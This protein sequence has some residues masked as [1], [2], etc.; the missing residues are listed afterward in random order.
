MSVEPAGDATPQE[1]AS[2]RE[3]EADEPLSRVQRWLCGGVGL[4][5]GGAGGVATFL[6]GSNVGGAPLLIGVGA[7][8]AY[9][10]L[11]GQR[12]TRL[13]AG[14]AS[15]QLAR[16]RRA[17]EDIASNPEVPEE[18][19]AEIAEAV[20]DADLRLSAPAVTSLRSAAN[21]QRRASYYELS[22]QTAIAR[23]RPDLYASQPRTYL[24]WDLILHG[25]GRTVPVEM[26]YVE[27]NYVPTHLLRRFVHRLNGSEGRH[28]LVANR[29]PLEGD[30]DR[31]RPL[32]EDRL[33]VATYNENE[34][35][36]NN[37]KEALNDLFPPE[38]SPVTT[39][40]TT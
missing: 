21:S 29:P 27:G 13:E 33:V 5:S 1:A 10:A 40:G 39:G 4:L 12:L 14:G 9:L 15:A 34:N 16:T 30:L 32:L 26:K 18:V 8:F 6:D 2:N 35:D 17:I 20:D 28:L 31:L 37:L 3:Q 24:G 19:K 23:L 22:V 36:E 38:V 7:V 25:H 11:T